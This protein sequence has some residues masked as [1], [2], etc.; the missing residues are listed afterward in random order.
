MPRPV[1]GA[2][3]PMCFKA[4]GRSHA[5]HTGSGPSGRALPESGDPRGCQ[6]RIRRSSGFVFFVRVRSA[7]GSPDT[8][9]RGH[10]RRTRS[11]L[12]GLRLAERPGDRT[13]SPWRED[14]ITVCECRVGV[15]GAPARRALRNHLAHQDLH[16]DPRRPVDSGQPRPAGRSDRCVLVR[17]CRGA[18]LRGR[19][20]P[21]PP[22]DHPHGRLA[23]GAPRD[24]RG[25][26]YR[27]AG[28]RLPG[29]PG[30]R[31]HDG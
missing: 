23:D 26:L 27:A 30:L 3:R 25:F 15:R 21:H 24:R 28:P 31:K 11:S 6:S 10:D 14:R 20:D 12:P 19:A 16:G 4:R 13:D 5:A 29:E 17:G 22:S 8:H 18:D 7:P 9:A 1:C 2:G